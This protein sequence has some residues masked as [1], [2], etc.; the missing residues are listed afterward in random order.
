MKLSR[1]S[2]SINETSEASYAGHP[3]GNTEIPCDPGIQIVVDTYSPVAVGR[4]LGDV[5]ILTSPSLA[6]A[7]AELAKSD[8]PFVLDMTYVG[9]VGT[10]A[11][12][13]LSD[14]ATTA[15]Y[16]GITWTLAAGRSLRHLLA[17]TGIDAKM[18]IC[19]SVEEASRRA[20]AA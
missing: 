3:T 12:S 9:F 5:D 14:F 10:S 19:R 15:R 6:L 18:S 11:L 16:E 17:A 7:L 20:R 13:V 1:T 4:V 8:T 2:I